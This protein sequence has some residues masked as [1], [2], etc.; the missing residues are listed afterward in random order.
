[1]TS[2]IEHTKSDA[3]QSI[4]PVQT[5]PKDGTVVILVGGI[6]RL[7]ASWNGRS[8]RF[9]GVDF[10]VLGRRRVYWDESVAPIDGWLPVHAGG[11]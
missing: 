4:Q 11:R 6:H 7:A 2:L 8:N 9:E 1:M 3:E 10:G 5:A